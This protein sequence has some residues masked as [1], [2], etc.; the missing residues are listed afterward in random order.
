MD[1]KWISDLLIAAIN[2]DLSLK[3][4]EEYYFFVVNFSDKLCND[5]FVGPVQQLCLIGSVDAAIKYSF[6]LVKKF[7]LPV[8][9]TI[10]DFICVSMFKLRYNDEDIASFLKSFDFTPNLTFISNLFTSCNVQL[11]NVKIFDVLNRLDLVPTSEFLE[12]ILVNSNPR[13]VGLI[14]KKLETFNIPFDSVICC[15]VIHCLVQIDMGAACNFLVLMKISNIAISPKIYC[16]IIKYCFEIGF[17]DVATLFLL[18][19]ASKID[20]IKITLGLFISETITR[21]IN[22]SN[23]LLPLFKLHFRLFKCHHNLFVP[24]KFTVNV[25]SRMYI[26]FKQLK[27]LCGQERYF[28]F[29]Y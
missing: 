15:G 9:T 7:N 19:S 6:E 13:L 22:F 17:I 8:S 26:C 11:S 12:K 2:E 4:F 27:N 23:D 16:I 1:S 25:K 29:D 28:D 20:D 18:H 21:K 14:L 5:M 10:V 3:V 24:G